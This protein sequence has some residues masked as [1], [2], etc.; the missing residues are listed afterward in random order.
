MAC[1]T[2]ENATTSKNSEH[3]DFYPC[4]VGNT[5]DYQDSIWQNGNLIEAKSLKIV[6]ASSEK[7]GINLN[8]ESGD[9]LK[10]LIRNDSVFEYKTDEN[11][12]SIVELAWI[13]T[14]G[15]AQYDYALDVDVMITRTVTK[16][17]SDY[18]VANR[19]YKNCF[20]YEDNCGS[21]TIIAS[22][23]GIIES[24]RKNCNNKNKVIHKR[25]L[26]RV[27]FK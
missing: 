20:R 1:V 8:C 9:G 27:N 7:S 12:N 14:D 4:S 21:Y 13:K 5:W 18:H 16:L 10:L 19:R 15:T 11:G 24:V 25:S 6:I 2:N 22:G 23:V 26:T 17:N 3:M